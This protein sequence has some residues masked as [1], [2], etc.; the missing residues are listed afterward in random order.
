MK[1]KLEELRKNILIEVYSWAGL[2]PIPGREGYIITKDQK[3][4]HY[5]EYQ[6][7]APY[8]EGKVTNEGISDGEKLSNEKY[9]K[10]I[11]F[12][13]EKILNKTF[14]YI[15]IFDASF[16][17]EGKYNKQSFNIINHLDLYEEINKII[18]GGK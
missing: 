3:I 17:I 12:I 7:I 16:H 15:Q 18:R 6:R 11:K 13:E 8:F 1:N 9:Q 4:Y 10:I 5:H 2:S 14:D